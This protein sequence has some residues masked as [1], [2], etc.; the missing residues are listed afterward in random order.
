[1]SASSFKCACKA[2]GGQ[3]PIDFWFQ[4]LIDSGVLHEYNRVRG[5]G[6]R[7]HVSLCVL[8]RFSVT[9]LAK[10]IVKNEF[11]TLAQ[12]RRAKH[13]RAWLA[14]AYFKEEELEAVWKV[15]QSTCS[16]KRSVVPCLLGVA[17]SCAH[18]LA[19]QKIIMQ[20]RSQRRGAQS[21]SQM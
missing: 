21:F 14:A 16:C 13:P 5:A 9:G 19:G 17:G 1:M 2:P 15:C 3:D 11:R 7:F 12:I 20:R 6:V 18:M 8:V 10:F 4:T